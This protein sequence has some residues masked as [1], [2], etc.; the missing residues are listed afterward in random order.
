MLMT[1]ND[2]KQ[3]SDTRIINGINIQKIRIKSNEKN[4]CHDDYFT[5]EQINL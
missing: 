4:I 2:L 3:K 5:I 1:I